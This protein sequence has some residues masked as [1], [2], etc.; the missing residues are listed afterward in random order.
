MSACIRYNEEYSRY[1]VILPDGTHL[2]AEDIPEDGIDEI[3]HPDDPKQKFI[4][5]LQTHVEED[6]Y[7]PNTVYKLEALETETE[8]GC[9]F[10]AEDEGEE[11]ERSRRWQ[12]LRFRPHS[13]S[14]PP[15]SSQRLT[16]PSGVSRNSGA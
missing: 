14:F 4:V 5:V 6:G 10:D 11:D 7:E 16:L 3:D 2:E 9:D 13:R 1:E 15:S 8:D 12:A